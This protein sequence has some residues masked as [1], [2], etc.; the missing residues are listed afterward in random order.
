M[1]GDSALP[2]DAPRHDANGLDLIRR[3]IRVRAWRRGRREMDLILGEFAD[4]NV[5][6]LE[7]EELAQFEALL[8]ADDDAAF[9]WFCVGAAPAPHDGS[10]FALILAYCARR[11]LL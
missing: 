11:R 1:I 2:T 8:D 7:A 3:R 4:A 10:L 6:M 5:D 9:G